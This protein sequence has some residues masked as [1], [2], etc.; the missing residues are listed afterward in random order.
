MATYAPIGKF[1]FKDP[2]LSFRFLLPSLPYG[3]EPQFVKS[4][5]V[6]YE[7]LDVEPHPVASTNFYYPTGFDASELVITFHENSTYDTTDKVM[8]WQH[9]VIDE[10]GFFGLPAHYKKDIPV[11]LLDTAYPV[12]RKKVLGRRAF[13]KGLPSHTYDVGESDGILCEVNFAID[14]L[15]VRS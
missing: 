10:D 5:A 14:R 7:V 15:L 4:V 12:I 8:K 6:N 9:E 2:A 11:A 3:L 13:P 1:L